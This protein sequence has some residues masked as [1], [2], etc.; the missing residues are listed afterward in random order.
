MTLKCWQ[1]VIE[2]RSFECNVSVTCFHPAVRDR[3]FQIVF[4]AAIWAAMIVGYQFRSFIVKS[5]S[6]QIIGAGR[7]AEV[8]GR[9]A[10]RLKAPLAAGSPVF[11]RIFKESKEL[12]LWL[13]PERGTSRGFVLFKT[14]PIANYGTGTLAPKLAEGDGQAPTGFY[15]VGAAQMKPDSDYHLAFN[16]G[17][18]NAYDRAKGRTGSF[19]M[20]HGSTASIGCYAMTDA[21][22]EE[23]YLLVDAAL[24]GGQKGVPVHAFPFRMSDERLHEAAADEVERS[25]LAEWENLKAGYDFFERTRVPPVVEVGSDGRYAFR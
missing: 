5:A 11:I 18:P 9:L 10:P 12:E 17:F 7:L 19:L 2:P 3:K 1:Q 22:I 8:R 21:L 23:I 14:Y 24:S 15:T 20:V 4:L 16:L 6:S 13:K 25:W